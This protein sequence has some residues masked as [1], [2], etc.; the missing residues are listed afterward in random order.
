MLFVDGFGSDK[1]ADFSVISEE[2][3]DRE[4]LGEGIGEFV[5]LLTTES[6]GETSAWEDYTVGTEDVCTEIGAGWTSKYPQHYKMRAA[7]LL[8]LLFPAT[9][10]DPTPEPL[11]EVFFS[12]QRSLWIACLSLARSFSIDH[13]MSLSP[14]LTRSVHS[15]DLTR[16]R[17]IAD[18]VE[19]CVK[20]A[21]PEQIQ[22]LLTQ[23]DE[24]DIL[25]EDWEEM[26]TVNET[27]YASADSDVALTES[28]EALYSAIREVRLT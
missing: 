7:V 20:T 2:T 5:G 10:S 24:F 23:D 25:D 16:R 6:Q 14:V 4:I 18:I 22:K 19:K 28:Q 1:R 9:F 3:S 13:E 11:D 12:E 8:V 21:T 27:F 15:K 26:I 17:I